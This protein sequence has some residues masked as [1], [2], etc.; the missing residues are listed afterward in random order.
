MQIKYCEKQIQELSTISKK[1]KKS[2]HH[3]GKKCLPELINRCHWPNST[4]GRLCHRQAWMECKVRQSPLVCCHPCVSARMAGRMHGRHPPP[5][6]R[7]PLP[8]R[9]HTHM[10]EGH[11]WKFWKKAA[12]SSACALASLRP[13]RDWAVFPL[14]PPGPPASLYRVVLGPKDP[15]L[16]VQFRLPVY[17]I[18][19]LST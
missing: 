8:S 18:L 5:P 19:H 17:C 10:A 11:A 15:P 13:G 7:G 4:A 6:S 3:W 14:L 12:V 1:K 16:M 9:P 2:P